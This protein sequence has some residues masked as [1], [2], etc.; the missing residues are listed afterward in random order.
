[1]NTKTKRR[2]ITKPIKVATFRLLRT[3]TQNIVKFCNDRK[4]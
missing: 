2:R 4:I 3:G 1:M